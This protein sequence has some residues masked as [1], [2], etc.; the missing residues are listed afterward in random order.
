VWTVLRLWLDGLKILGS[1]LA[2][3]GNGVI[4]YEAMCNVHLTYEGW[5][6][7]GFVKEGVGACIVTRRR[8]VSKYSVVVREGELKLQCYTKLWWGSRRPGKVGGKLIVN[9]NWGST[10]TSGL[11]KY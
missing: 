8:F 6:G 10:T 3:T 5:C 4:G 2:V 11:Y 7:G 1:S 9:F